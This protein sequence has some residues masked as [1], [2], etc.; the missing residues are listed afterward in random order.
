MKRPSLPLLLLILL[1]TF[2]LEAQNIGINGN[3][4]PPDNSALLDINANNK[5]LLVPRVALT[6]TGDNVTVTAPANSL[7]VYN[8]ATASD[9]TPGYYYRSGAI[10]V[11]L[12]AGGDAW[13]TSGN[14]G[15]N[16]T[17]NFIGTADNTELSIRVNSLDA[18][19]IQQDLDIGMGTTTPSGKL[20]VVGD[21]RVGNLNPP[22]TGTFPDYGSRLYFSGGPSP[23]PYNSDNSDPIWMA[24]HN[25]GQD[26]TELRMHLSDNCTQ[27]QDAFI[28]QAGGSGCG[29]TPYFRFQANG[30][31]LKP[32][33]GAW[34]ALSDRRLKKNITEFQDGLSALKAIRPVSFE[35]NGVADTPDDGTVYIGVI[36]QELAE[37]ASY[38]VSPTADGNYLSVDPSAFTYV[39]INSV[40]EQQN[41]IENL[42][43]RNGQLENEL[44]QLRQEVEAIKVSLNQEARK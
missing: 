26:Q 7:L 12:L 15:T 11:R 42:E 32:G 13:T 3:G 43:Q 27:A 22:N 14:T 34:T 2:S 1:S 29:F 31:A 9:V 37:T 10:W 5:G 39:L 41:Q 8:T 6:G 21:V 44:A 19:R 30:I 36:A 23:A 4:A 24:R 25:V 35:Y 17:A 33:G 38:M 20:H 16:P 28:I 40:K 18:I